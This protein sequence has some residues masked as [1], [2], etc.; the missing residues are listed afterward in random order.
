MFAY[1]IAESVRTG[2]RSAE[3]VIRE[4]LAKAEVVQAKTN[5]FITIAHE[6]ALA[7]AKA[8]DASKAYGVLAGVPV[9]VKDNI[10]TKDILTT[11]AS[12]SLE[13]FIPPYSATVVERLEKAGAIVIAKANLDEFGM[14]GSNENSAFGAVKNPWD[15]SRVPGGSSGGSAV[16]V[17]TDVAPIALGTDTGGSVRLPAAFNGAIGFKPTYGRLSRYGVIAFASSLDQVGVV[18]RS[19]K[20]LALAMDVMGGHDPHDATSLEKDKPQ[21][22]G[23]L[24][25]ALQDKSLQGLRIGVVKELSTEGNSPGILEALERTKKTLEA[26]GAT[27]AEA[28]LPTAPYGIATYY[29]VAPAEASSNLARFDAMVYSTRLGADALDNKDNNKLVDNSKLGQAE[30]MMKSRGATFGKEVRRRILMGTYALSAGYYDAYYG[31]ALKVRRLIANDFEKAFAQFDLL[32][33]PTAPSV[34]YKMG[35]KADP[36]AMYL[37]DID[38]VLGNLVGLP[39]ISIPAGTAEDNMPC[40]VHFFAP[41]LQDEKLMGLV[42]GLEHHGGAAFS[43]SVLSPS[44]FSPSANV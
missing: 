18:C 19:S 4:A 42:A 21:F 2:Q 23:G 30:V 28:S 38:T 17:A 9:V 16:A 44:A 3:E 1:E 36:L 24:E 25:Q 15:T 39:A 29:L 35:E 41:A 12:K 6:Q 7:K 8:L 31:K 32:M 43:L 40:G 10:C 22:V 14:G 11:A 27:V 26:L 5:A 37:M 13:H 33:T 20:D 34:A